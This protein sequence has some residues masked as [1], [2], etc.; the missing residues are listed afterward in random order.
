MTVVEYDDEFNDEYGIDCE[1]F[2]QFDAS[3]PQCNSCD[4]FRDCL[5]NEE[6]KESF[7][8]TPDIS[9]YDTLFN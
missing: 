4:S 5:D 7:G 1:N 8:N 2:G 6:V 9:L 3:D